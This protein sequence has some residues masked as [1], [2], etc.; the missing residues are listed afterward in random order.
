MTYLRF[1]IRDLLWAMVMVGL[2]I[3]WWSEYPR[4]ASLIRQNQELSRA[5]QQEGMRSLGLEIDM[6]MMRENPNYPTWKGNPVSKEPATL[7]DPLPVAALSTTAR[8]NKRRPPCP[9]SAAS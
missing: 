4:R 7:N 8:Q 2:A 5:L 9:L 1:G 6:G 3:G